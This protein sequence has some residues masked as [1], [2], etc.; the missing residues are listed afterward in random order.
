MR[1]GHGRL[2]GTNWTLGT[3]RAGASCRTL[4][5]R[6]AS[7]SLSVRRS[8]AFLV[9]WASGRSLCALGTRRRTFSASR[10]FCATRTILAATRTI[11][12]T[13]RAT[14]AT[15]WTTFA[16]T[17]RALATR[18]TATLRRVGHHHVGTLFRVRN[19]FNA[20][21]ARIDGRGSLGRHDRKYFNTFHV[22]LDISAIDVTDHGAARNE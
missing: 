17:I 16:T 15:A 10:S 12:S 11:L 20:L 19:E 13:T 7:R 4:R 3:R 1:R 21:V 9:D 22:L 18:T 5:S 8:T 14:F 6:S 2:C